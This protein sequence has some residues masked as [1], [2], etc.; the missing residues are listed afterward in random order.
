MVVQLETLAESTN[1]KILKEEIKKKE[2]QQP[3]L[4]GS[5]QSRTR[6]PAQNL[7][8]KHSAS[9]RSELVLHVSAAAQMAPAA[10]SCLVYPAQPPGPAAPLQPH[11]L[12]N[13]QG[14]GG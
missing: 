3:Y 5:V 8:E 1:V 11:V 6:S 9:S 10:Q 2:S 4:Q 12:N 7:C 14:V 13:L